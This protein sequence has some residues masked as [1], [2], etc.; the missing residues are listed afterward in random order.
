VVKRFCRSSET[1]WDRVEGVVAVCDARSGEVYDLDPV[2][3]LLWSLVDGRT[4]AELVE[5]VAEARREDA[6]ERLG[7]RVASLILLFEGSGLIRA[8][9]DAPAAPPA[10]EGRA[11]ESNEYL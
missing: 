4:T 2:A 5:S 3:G 8:V 10:L 9:A 1:F 6:H 11:V 7:A